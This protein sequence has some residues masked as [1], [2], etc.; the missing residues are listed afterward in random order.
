MKYENNMFSTIISLSQTFRAS[1]VW[2]SP[3]LTMSKLAEA[4]RTF[5]AE[6]AF[7]SAC[8]AHG[9]RLDFVL[10]YD[11]GDV[12]IETASH[13]HELGGSFCNLIR[14]LPEPVVIENPSSE[15]AKIKV[16]CDGGLVDVE[17]VES[18]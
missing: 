11:I 10:K 12:T 5:E 7:D 3:K 4:E 1:K 15:K 13:D 6:L 2:S 17:F 8:T 16:V 9:I 18:S 14:V